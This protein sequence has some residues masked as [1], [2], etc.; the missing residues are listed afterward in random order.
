MV[1]SQVQ[2]LGRLNMFS[3]II[4]QCLVA[5]GFFFFS[6]GLLAGARLFARASAERSHALRHGESLPASPPES[7]TLNSGLLLLAG[8]IAF[9][10]FCNLLLIIPSL[11]EWVSGVP[12]PWI[13]PLHHLAVALITALT[14]GLIFIGVV[15]CVR[16]QTTQADRA[17]SDEKGLRW[18]SRLQSVDR[19]SLTIL[20]MVTAIYLVA[21][22]VVG[23]NYDTGLYH[24]P[25]VL[26]FLH[27]GPEIGVANLHVRYSFY[28]VQLFG[29]VP[30]QNLS[31]G[32]R[33]MS[34]SLNLIFLSAFLLTCGHEIIHRASNSHKSQ[35]SI[36]GPILFLIV[37]LGLGIFSPDSLISY[38]AD[39]ALSLSTLALLHV[40]IFS[41][42]RLPLTQA[43]I[44]APLLVL[45][46]LSGILSL[47]AIVLLQA[48]RL[49]IEAMTPGSTRL[50]TTLRRSWQQTGSKALIL[51]SIAGSYLTM[52]ITNVITSGYLLFPEVRTGPLTAHAV[53]PEAV[54]MMKNK[55]VT[56]YAR[57]NDNPASIPDRID[58]VISL[59]DWL[60]AFL[61]S[62]RGQLLLFWLVS[63]LLLTL[64]CTALWILSRRRKDIGR[65]AALSLTLV[66]LSLLTLLVLPPNPRFFPWVGALLA[67]AWGEMFMLFPIVGLMAITVLM[68]AIGFRLQRPFLVG[69]GNEPFTTWT[70]PP[71]QISA[72]K[73]RQPIDKQGA[74]PFV[75]SPINDD[76][77][78]AIEPPCS[79]FPSLLKE[80]G[81]SA[82][83]LR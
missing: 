40:F 63:A 75:R 43:W 29:Q 58:G 13:L 42:Q 81:K 41:E 68:A 10:T 23:M 45:L 59:T 66:V 18:L 60:P 54:Q 3:L 53:P 31:P 9:S 70:L 83:P 76:Q 46:K 65:L 39:L 8:V 61:R 16:P 15:C 14:L 80:R 22:Q 73:S 12:G 32:E 57:F 20:S 7:G 33:I 55:W 72:W 69:L 30:W 21:V 4:R 51:L 11:L 34:P 64:L 62:D 27:Y 36:F 1:H 35:H 37:G 82:D 24:L 50:W 67:F 38:D 56:D 49:V 26:H 5:L 77:C 19:L 25:S 78:W 74:T 2:H 28:N 71:G 47:L 52:V 17:G 48:I 6:V 79:P 44:L